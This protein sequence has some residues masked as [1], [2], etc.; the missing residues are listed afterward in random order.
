MTKTYDNANR[1][2]FAVFQT[3]SSF[4]CM[5]G[6]WPSKAVKDREI[7]DIV[8]IDG[9]NNEN[10]CCYRFLSID[11]YNRCQSKSDYRQLSM[12][13][14]V[15]RYRFLSIALAGPHGRKRRFIFFASKG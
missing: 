11:R 3:R 9:A 14:V 13:R 10:S 7:D 15:I 1:Y 4:Q 12:Y 5:I 6:F 2:L 8:K